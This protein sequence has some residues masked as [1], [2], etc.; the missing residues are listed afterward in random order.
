MVRWKLKF[1]IITG[2]EFYKF[3]NNHS[4]S[5]SSCPCN[6]IDQ[7]YVQKNIAGNLYLDKGRTIQREPLTETA[8]EKNQARHG[9]ERYAEFLYFP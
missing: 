9:K 3:A 8:V 6:A 1:S 4:T 7:D 5:V 2:H